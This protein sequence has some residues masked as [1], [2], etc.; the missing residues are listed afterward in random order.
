MMRLDI[1]IMLLLALFFYMLMLTHLF[2][3]IPIGLVVGSVSMWIGWYWGDRL[4]DRHSKE[5]E[6]EKDDE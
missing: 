6:K 1:K 5:A 2:Q 4:G 3:S